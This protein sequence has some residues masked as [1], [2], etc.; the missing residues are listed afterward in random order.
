M[1]FAIAGIVLSVI[2]LFF[3]VSA[4][5]MARK[6]ELTSTEKQSLVVE[7]VRSRI[8]SSIIHDMVQVQRENR[9]L[10]RLLEERD[11]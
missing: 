3:S 6:R 5:W 10:H 7:E 1:G 11:D 2:S 4:I 9:R 8:N